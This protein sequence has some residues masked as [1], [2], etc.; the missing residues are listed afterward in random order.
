MSLE[1]E[2]RRNM[3]RELLRKTMLEFAAIFSEDNTPFGCNCR[4]YTE[5]AI[6]EMH[7]NDGAWHA[8][9]STRWYPPKDRFAQ[10]DKA[11]ISLCDITQLCSI[12]FIKKG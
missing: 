10:E 1:D 11:K 5:S 8:K 12:S 4:C 3:A 9:P 6:N 2:L 7:I